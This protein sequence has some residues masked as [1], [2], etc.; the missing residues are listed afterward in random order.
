MPRSGCAGADRPRGG[1]AQNQVTSGEDESR[2]G[3]MRGRD[4]DDHSGHSASRL[5]ITTPP[6]RTAKSRKVGELP[7][8]V[9]M[10]RGEIHRLGA[11][12]VDVKELPAVLVEVAEV[13][14]DRP[15]LG[16]GFPPL[17]PDA[18]RAQHLVA[19]GV[20]RRRCR[21]VVEAVAH[22]DARQR[23]LLHAVHRVGHGD[24]AALQD[25]RHDIR[26]VVRLVAQLALCRDPRDRCPVLDG[27]PQPGISRAERRVGTAGVSSAALHRKSEATGIEPGDVQPG[28][29][30]DTLPPLT[31]WR[32]ATYSAVRAGLDRR[33][34]SGTGRGAGCVRR[35]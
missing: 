21:G 4:S 19:L 26:A 30:R 29:M 1:N 5:V 6:A 13:D 34:P 22:R 35:R 3:G 25:G 11:V 20:S 31:P 23:S 8:L 2:Q 24:A 18:A 28:C 33:L 32:I 15:V 16:R 17:V 10:V 27:G 14:R 9:G 7:D 12:L